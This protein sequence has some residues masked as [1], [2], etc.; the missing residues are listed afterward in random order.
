MTMIV[1]L[2]EDQES[3][4]LTL[5]D[6]FLVDSKQVAEMTG[7]PI[8]KVSSVLASLTRFDG[9][10]NEGFRSVHDFNLISSTP[11]C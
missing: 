10:K 11:R 8:E 6:A 2:L 5:L 4:D 9:E 7:Y 1:N 3:E